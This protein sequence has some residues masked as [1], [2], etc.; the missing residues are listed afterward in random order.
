MF[1]ACDADGDRR[2]SPAELKHHARKHGLNLNADELKL[3][4]DVLGKGTGFSGFCDWFLQ[5]RGGDTAEEIAAVR[6]NCSAR[7]VR[8]VLFRIRYA[9]KSSIE[10]G[11]H[12]R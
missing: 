12:G 2:V 8:A 7:H 6:V 4:V 9:C 1:L 11:G 10:D 3:A 5:R